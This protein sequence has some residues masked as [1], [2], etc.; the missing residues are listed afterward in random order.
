MTNPHPGQ[1]PAEGSRKVIDREL[2]RKA[3]PQNTAD[4]HMEDEEGAAKATNDNDL[5]TGHSH[6][7]DGGAD[8]S[9]KNS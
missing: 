4:E 2:A 7:G 5:S 1:D 9:K 3:K 6:P 8:N